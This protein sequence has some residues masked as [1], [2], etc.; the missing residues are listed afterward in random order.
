MEKVEYEILVGIVDDTIKGSQGS[1]FMEF[2]IRQ[3]DWC[4][5]DDFDIKKLQDHI[6]E[7]QEALDE[8]KKIETLDF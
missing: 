4:I 7:L 5:I 8:M 1:S 6:A 2:Q 3:G